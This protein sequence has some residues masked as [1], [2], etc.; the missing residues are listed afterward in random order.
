MAAGSLRGG[1]E[2]AA[3][4]LPV[5]RGYCPP[6]Q[7]QVLRLDVLQLEDAILLV[8]RFLQV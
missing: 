1:L 7:L 5:A 3:R 6:A 8:Q 4:C 2:L